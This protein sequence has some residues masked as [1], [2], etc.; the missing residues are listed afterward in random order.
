MEN[1]RHVYVNDDTLLKMKAISVLDKWFPNSI[2]TICSCH[3]LW[4]YS[5]HQTAK[6][7]CDKTMHNE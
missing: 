7:Q 2:D 6:N 5:Q 3:L 1:W 4:V